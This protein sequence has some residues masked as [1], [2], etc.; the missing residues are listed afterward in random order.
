MKNTVSMMSALL[1]S[2]ASIAQTSN[3]GIAPNENI[4][5][6]EFKNEKGEIIENGEDLINLVLNEQTPNEIIQNEFDQTL[7][8]WV[9]STKTVFTKNEKGQILSEVIYSWNNGEWIPSQKKEFIHKNGL[10][11]TES[12]SI[13]ESE[14]NSWQATQKIE[15]SYDSNGLETKYALYVWDN[16]S[17]R[18]DLENHAYFEY[19]TS[20]QLTS[21]IHK[22]RDKGFLKKE[23]FFDENG[24]SNGSATYSWDKENASWTNLF[25][26]ETTSHISKPIITT[27]EYSWNSETNSWQAL[28]MDKTS[29]NKKGKIKSNELIAWN[30]NTANWDNKVMKK[31][32]VYGQGGTLS[33]TT[34]GIFNTTDKKW[35]NH[36]IESHQY[37]NAGRISQTSN[38]SLNTKT[39]ELIPLSQQNNG[40]ADLFV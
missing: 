10:C 25:K 22:S 31:R 24:E 23:F 1:M 27:I 3:T 14:T 40:Y 9:N 38:F 17:K 19:N 5:V 12:T 33:S 7:Q 35:E 34:T 29:F 18:Y 11:T 21:Y 26:E 16:T 39:Q 30:S 37:D 36:T 15:K 28:N 32:Y 2:L 13:W 8:E 6:S 4:Q 20:N